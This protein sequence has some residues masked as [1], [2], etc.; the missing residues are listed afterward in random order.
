M[1]LS[2]GVATGIQ[3]SPVNTPSLSEA[4]RRA[5][6]LYANAPRWKQIQQNAMKADVSW[7]GPARAYVQ[8]YRQILG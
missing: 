5:A 4:I 8:L 6:L 3:F 7:D 2:A 1:A